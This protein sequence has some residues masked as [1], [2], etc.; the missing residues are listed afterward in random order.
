MPRTASL[1]LS[2]LFALP[3]VQAVAQTQQPAQ[4]PA[5]APVTGAAGRSGL[6]GL[7]DV[8]ATVTSG[9]Q[10][11]SITKG[12][13]ITFLS[14]YP[15]PKPEDR[16]AVYRET[17]ESL[18]NTKLLTQFLIRQ[19]IVVP[20]EKIDA[21]IER[22]K[23]QLKADNQDLPT[24]LRQN[25]IS[26]ESIREEYENRIRWAQY[27]EAKATDAALRKFVAENRDLFNGTQVRASHIMLKADPDA[28]EA[29]KEKIRQKLV[30]IKKEIDDKK[31]TFAQAANKYS[32]DPANEGGA[33]GDLDYFSLTTGLI[34]EF[35]NV[36]FK[37]R[38]G[39]I[40]DPVETPYGYHLIMVTDR[41][42]GKQIDFDQ[43]K[44]VILQAFGADLQKNVV[45]AERKTAKIDIKPIPRDLFPAAE[46]VPPAETP[47]A[48]APA[49]KAAAPAKP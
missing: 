24:A 25:N 23:Q 48:A 46:T 6:T 17:L 45:T 16:E 30:A 31:L 29:D 36:A 35:T 21:E 43:N 34:E 14:H 37:M 11:A 20:P 39:A 12:E 40:S 2:A 5:P 47:K 41:K 44:A 22:L 10:T 4:A 42:E 28:S 49:P 3:A 9:G 33:G 32:E 27:L 18:I 26:M 7:T 1:L 8:V 19:K 13:V 15:A 38:K